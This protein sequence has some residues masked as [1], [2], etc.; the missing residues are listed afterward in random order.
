MLYFDIMLTVTIPDMS[1][2]FVNFWG[3]N[4]RIIKSASWS[5]ILNKL[6]KVQS[7]TK[8]TILLFIII[9]LSTAKAVIN[10]WKVYDRIYYSDLG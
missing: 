3:F 10:Y 4:F 8:L 6:D 7:R 9:D 1:A 2:R 5:K